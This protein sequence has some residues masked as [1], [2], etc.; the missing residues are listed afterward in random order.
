MH[1]RQMPLPSSV[2]ELWQSALADANGDPARAL[3]FVLPGEQSSNGFSA[4]HWLGRQVIDSTLE[5][6][7]LQPLVQEMNVEECLDARRVV[8]W[9]A[10]TDEG[11]AALMR[12]ELEHA[13]QFEA[14]GGPL[15][16][17]YLLAEGVLSEHAGGLPGS[18]LLYQMIPV[19]FD[20][21][22]AAAVFVRSRFGDERI[23]ELLETGDKDSAAF[24]A[25]VP[26]PPIESLPDRMVQFLA[27]M[28]DLC[29]RLA[30]RQGSEFTTI[31]DRHWKGAG[32]IWSRLVAD[33]ELKVP[34]R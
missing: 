16:G 17:L 12:H 23:T 22:A 6:D 33:D 9:G 32:A 1:P 20:A 19:E 8:I 34:R 10:R 26:P 29:R 13:H 18:A 5:P 31:L 21:N 11:L 28:P 14:F 27:I 4:R 3:L 30:A 7:E 2:G 25:L 15:L 24:R